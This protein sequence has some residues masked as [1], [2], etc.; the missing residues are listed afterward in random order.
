ME[1][2]E[3][4]ILADHAKHLSI[5]TVQAVA[6]RMSDK[7]KFGH[8]NCESPANFSSRADSL[9]Q[10]QLCDMCAASTGSIGVVLDFS[11]SSA[12]SSDWLQIAADLMTAGCGEADW[13]LTSVEGDKVE[14]LSSDG[15]F[16][17]TSRLYWILYQIQ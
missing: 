8:S 1:G 7:A 11:E 14:V 4:Y 17:T 5:C 9:P 13:A 12:V 10:S 16:H 2:H 15:A 6:L 3:L